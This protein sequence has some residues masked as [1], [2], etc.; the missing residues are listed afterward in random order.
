MDFFFD[1]SL[2][3]EVLINVF[4]FR[5]RVNVN[6]THL[7]QTISIMNTWKATYNNRR[8]LVIIIILIIIDIIHLD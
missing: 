8:L 7:I 1:I 3:E 6:F 2:I 4:P 5:L